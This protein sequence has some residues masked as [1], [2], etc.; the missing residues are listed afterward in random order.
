[1]IDPPVISDDDE[2]HLPGPMIVDPIPPPGRMLCPHCGTVYAATLGRHAPG[3]FAM[4][5]H[6]GGT[7]IFMPNGHP[8]LCTYDEMLEA[9]SDPRVRLMQVSFG[10]PLPPET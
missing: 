4:C 3:E 2:P 10:P 1:M 5:A 6:C 7:V 8:R 9:E